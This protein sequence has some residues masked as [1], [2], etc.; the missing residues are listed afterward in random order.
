[1]VRQAQLSDAERICEIIIYGWRTAYIDFLGEEA[2]Y[3]D[4]S[5]VKRYKTL[6]TTLE[7][8]H[9]FYVYEE[10]GIVKGFMRLE[11]CTEQDE[12][13]DDG[14]AIDIEEIGR[15]IPMEL[16]AIYVEPY[17]KNRGIGSKLIQEAEM[18][19]A[20]QSQSEIR[21]WVLEKNHSSRKFYEKNGFAATGHVKW[22]EKFDQNEVRYV[23]RILW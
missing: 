3:K 11:K 18:I 19:A 1:M 16:V 21:L 7:S 8:D 20:S 13:E 15:A 12:G 10:N 4:M 5:V 23:K 6:Y 17:F 2:L 14:A 22:L 9:G